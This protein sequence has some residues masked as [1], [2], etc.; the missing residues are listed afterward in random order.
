MFNMDVIRLKRLFENSLNC[1]TYFLF[2]PPPTCRRSP[3]RATSIALP[4]CRTDTPRAGSA[5][6]L[7]SRKAAAAA[8]TCGAACRSMRKTPASRPQAT[9]SRPKNHPALCKGARWF[10]SRAT[11]RTNSCAAASARAPTPRTTAFWNRPRS[12]RSRACRSAPKISP[13]F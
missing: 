5:K 11:R 9:M 2:D 10:A 6:R 13:A 7:A 4:G 8:C 3:T 12:P 1:R